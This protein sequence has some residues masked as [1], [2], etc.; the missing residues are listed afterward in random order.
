MVH[1]L[2]HVILRHREILLARAKLLTVKTVYPMIN[3]L[4]IFSVKTFIV[5][6]YVI[7]NSSFV[8]FFKNKCYI[9]FKNQ[10]KKGENNFYNDRI[11]VQKREFKESCNGDLQCSGELICNL[12]SLSNQKSNTCLLP[13]GHSC[14]DDTDCTN[15]LNCL[16][17]K[18]CGCTKVMFFFY[19]EFGLLYNLDIFL[20]KR[21]YLVQMK[22]FVL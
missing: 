13:F 14:K 18:T 19:L 1:Q 22:M 3:V 5:F 4:T 9:I 6:V 17:N 11:C 2:L 21:V 7:F 20:L 10:K 15:N 12:F 16:S 8:R